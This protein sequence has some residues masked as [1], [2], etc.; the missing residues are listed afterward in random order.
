MTRSPPPPSEQP[1]GPPA[2]VVE[3]GGVRFEGAFRPSEREYL[4]AQFGAC[5]FRLL[6]RSGQGADLALVE[7]EAGPP[8]GGGPS[9]LS[10]L[11]RRATYVLDASAAG[12]VGA[13][14]GPWG[15]LQLERVDGPRDLAARYPGH[16]PDARLRQDW[17][18]RLRRAVQDVWPALMVAVATIWVLAVAWACGPLS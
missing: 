13:G 1:A 2:D 11:P 7:W 10:G 9:P 4:A 3:I 12:E 16:F 6:A 14:A 5:A 18:D 8:Q 15:G 17:R